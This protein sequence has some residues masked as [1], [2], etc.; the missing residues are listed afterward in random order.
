MMAGKPTKR[1]ANALPDPV[2]CK[3]TL[4]LPVE[5]AKRLGVESEMRRVSKS[6]VAIEVLSPYLM[7]WRI[8]NTIEV[9]TTAGAESAA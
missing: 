5:L 9:T 7:R 8:P 2:T 3:V 1:R 6:Q 4:T